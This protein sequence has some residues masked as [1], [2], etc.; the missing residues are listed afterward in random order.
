MRIAAIGLA[1]LVVLLL[2]VLLA[3]PRLIDANRFK[4]DIAAALE[5][6]TGLQLELTGPLGISFLPSPVISAREVRLAN[7]PGAALPDMVRLRALEVKPALWPLLSGKLE[8]RSATLVDADIDLEIL[9][10]G[11][12][13]WLRRASSAAPSAEAVPSEPPAAPQDKPDAARSRA[14]LAIDR[15]L[16]QNATVTYRSGAKVERFEHINATVSLGS[17]AGPFQA[18]GELVA[19]GAGM[20]FEASLGRLDEDEAP[21]HLAL[22]AKPAG[23]L[24]FE[25]L[26]GGR[27]S[28]RSIKGRLKVTAED[29][30][31]LA[32][33]ARLSLPGALAQP[34]VLT[35]DL[36]GSAEQVALDHLALDLGTAHGQ[37]KLLLRPGKPLAAELTLSVGRLD[38][39]RWLAARK[40]EAAPP[41]GAPD[42]LGATAALAETPTATV[43]IPAAG[44]SGAA[45]FTLPPD[46]DL[47]VDLGVEAILWRNGLIRDA[48]FKARIEK[49]QMTLERLAALLPGGS[50]LAVS[51]TAAT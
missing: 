24:N 8:L 50:D 39:D 16:L 35:G 19:R 47:A 25:G 31:T 5:K 4:G 32:S 43:A 42:S 38:L 15:L 20:S 12:A 36:S 34:V 13:N 1:I 33:L 41:A 49:G 29:L 17:L 37:G 22:T 21:V 40:A 9:P 14:N 7:P 11:T 51:G 26:L 48:R 45:N 23:R 2:G 46:L 3:A 30:A 6:R 44:L 27:T 10:D 18:Q 28:E